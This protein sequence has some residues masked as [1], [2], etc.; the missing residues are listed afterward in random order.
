M[1]ARRGRAAL[2]QPALAGVLAGLV[3]CFTSF[4]WFASVPG[5]SGVEGQDEQIAR[6]ERSLGIRA[7]IAMPAPKPPHLAPI[8]DNR[9]PTDQPTRVRPS[10]DAKKP[11]ATPVSGGV[12]ARPLREYAPLRTAETSPIPVP[13]TMYWHPS[14]FAANGDVRI[15]LDMPPSEGRYRVRIDGHD[16]DGRFGSTEFQVETQADRKDA[17][18]IKST[19][20]EKK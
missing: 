19:D 15:K 3:V 20:K 11:S 18:S 9:A 13:E 4:Y 2:P 1:A 14:L 16:A 10:G 5:P 8:I 7:S 12:S 17:K 6:V